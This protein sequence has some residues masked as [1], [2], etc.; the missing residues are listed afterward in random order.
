[1]KNNAPIFALFGLMIVSLACGTTAP[2]DPTNTIDPHAVETM[3]AATVQALATTPAP[4][5]ATAEAPPTHTPTTEPASP[6]LT[7]QQPVCQPQ[8]PSAQAQALPAGFIASANAQTVELFDTEGNVLGSKQTPTLSWLEP[9][10][11]HLGGGLSQGVNAIPL[12]YHSL[13]NNGVL[14]SS[15]GG[16]GVQIGQTPGLV[17]LT[18]AEGSAVIAY[19][20]SDSDQAAGGWVSELYA[21]EIA[22]IDG[23][24]ALSSRSEGDGFVIYPLAVHTVGGAGRGVWYTLSMWGI[25]NINFP[26]YNGLY[27]YDLNNGQVS[28]Y[29]SFDNR[30]IGFSPNQAM[31]AFAPLQNGQPGGIEVGLTVKNL[32]TC[33]E[34][35]IAL[36]PN[37]NL[38]AGYVVFSPDN[39]YLAWLEASGP[40]N[41][42][43]QMRLRVAE[44]ANGNILVDS[45]TPSLSSLAGGEVPTWVQPV[46]WLADHLLLLEIG[47]PSQENP[48]IVVWAPDPDYPL[49]PALGANQAA[50]LSEGVF[51]GFVYP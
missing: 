31:M 43:A 34:T 39:Q 23:A 5:P 16:G 18:G 32:I 11:V 29:L 1:M 17:A 36:N 30:L 35:F 21:G 9:A 10:Q 24:Q 2:T 15:S 14:K 25:G 3:V 40:N 49:D 47:V 26:P 28:E 13:E 22:A 46:G 19:S 8:H 50:A 6:T 41:M 4:P 38:G 42:Q 44:T 33:Q 37:T 20:T 45:E 48:L 12:V 27:Y 7:E 51:A